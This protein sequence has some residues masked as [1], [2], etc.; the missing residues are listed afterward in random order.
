MHAL[1]FAVMKADDKAVS[2]ASP[3]RSAGRLQQTPAAA[4]RRRP[5]MLN[6]HSAL[7]NFAALMAQPLWSPGAASTPQ[8]F[9]HRKGL[10][11]SLDATGGASP[12]GMPSA[13]DDSVKVVL[14]IRPSSK[15]DEGE[16]MCLQQTGVNMLS[17]FTAP[18]PTH[19]TLDHVAGPSSTQASLF[20]VVGRPIVENTLAGFHSCVIAY[21]QTGSGKVTR[22]G[23]SVACATCRAHGGLSRVLCPADVHDVGGPAR[24]RGGGV[25]RLSRSHTPHFR[26]PV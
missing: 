13:P 5:G 11:S 3:P 4:T 22:G 12:A 24:G 14:R 21:G 16:A 1:N 6:V 19:Y 18:E 17:L 23:A 26:P 20:K 10:F 15:R 2:A 25:A 8:L 9:T 7:A